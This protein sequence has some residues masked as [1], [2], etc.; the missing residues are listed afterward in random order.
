MGKQTH[1]LDCLF[2]TCVVDRSK[3][4]EKVNRHL[5]GQTLLVNTFLLFLWSLLG[6]SS[7]SLFRTIDFLPSALPFLALVC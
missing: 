3:A 5:I 4:L 1:P 2:K 7:A 6:P